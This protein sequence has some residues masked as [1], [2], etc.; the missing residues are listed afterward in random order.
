LKTLAEVLALDAA[1]PREGV[2]PQQPLVAVR[3]GSRPSRG[4]D[5]P[6]AVEDSARIRDGTRD[7]GGDPMPDAD[8][9][10]GVARLIVAARPDAF[11]GIRP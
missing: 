1:E 11:T 10:G 4:V 5:Q 2:E 8:E 7:R 3:T 6:L 9:I